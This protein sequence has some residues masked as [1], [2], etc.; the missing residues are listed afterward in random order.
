ML[1]VGIALSL[2][3]LWHTGS[4]FAKLDL[5]TGDLVFVAMLFASGEV[6]RRDALRGGGG[7]GGGGGVPLS[8]PFPRSRAPTLP[9]SCA[10]R[11]CVC[12]VFPLTHL[13]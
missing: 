12:C 6:S 7:G 1:G 9:R 3:V 13:R 4:H 10:A 2:A 11:V 8:P 5:A